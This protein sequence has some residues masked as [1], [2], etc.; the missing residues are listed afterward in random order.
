MVK[1]LERSLWKSLEKKFLVYPMQR[2][3]ICVFVWKTEVLCQ[4]FFIKLLKN[5]VFR[6]LMG[7]AIIIR[8]MV[9]TSVC[10]FDDKRNIS[11]D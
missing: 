10:H 3:Q 8:T 2:N 7:Y 6:F 5:W 9:C 4:F 1:K 11:A